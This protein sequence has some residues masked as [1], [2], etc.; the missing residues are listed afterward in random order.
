MTT[1]LQVRAGQCSESG[2][3]VR[4]EDSCGVRLAEGPLLATKGIA[5]VI[6]DGVSGS[7]GGRV[8]AETCVQGFL[9]DYY[10]TPDSWT[11]K[12]SCDKVLSALN[13]WLYGQGQQAVGGEHELVTTF[14]ALVLK[15]TTAY[16]FHVGDT[17]IYRLRE[18]EL[19]QLTRD[20]RLRRGRGR[21]YLARAMGVDA[22]VQ[23]DYRSLP[24]AAGD[25]FVLTSDG[26]HDTLGERAL[27]A[28][29]A[30]RADDPEAASR[31]L[32]EHALAAGST[33]NC[34]AQVLRVVALPL[35]D[36]S[37]LYRRL[38]ELPFPPPL[39]P[40]AILDGYRVLRELHASSRTQVFLA[41]DG[42]TGGTCALKTPSVNFEDDPGYIARFRREAWVGRRVHSPHVLRVL[43][44]ARP[45]RFL[46][47]VTE[48]LEGQTLRQWLHDHPHPPLAQVRGIVAQVAAGLRALHRL[49]MV[50]R[51]L[52]PDNVL[53][54]LSG[55]AHII[56]F[57][58]VRIRG[59]EEIATPLPEQHLLGTR[60][61]T[62]PECF[63]GH[64]GDARSD[65]FSLAVLTYEL[66]TGALPY[67]AGAL[68]RLGK[69]RPYRSVLERAPDVPPWVDA[70]LRKALSWEPE[71][72]F[73]D[74]MEFVH[75]LHHPPA[76]PGAAS[77][78][79]PLIQR[80]PLAFWRGLS[81]LLLV[82]CILLT[83]LLLR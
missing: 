8:A 23:I 6:A 34:T 43:D 59:L 19:V 32:V 45:R 54:D 66:L 3:K 55:Q 65:Q 50:H 63:A 80:N 16:L 10:S 11:V 20:H 7:G 57:G 31:A 75:A 56:D 47:T 49:E 2:R 41:L 52:K 51:D 67:G 70:V 4:N 18:G 17:R 64:P 81:L 27:G 22:G 60:G 37:E 61:Y 40:G 21:S 46:Y 71:R 36:E 82:L 1:Q 53:I 58:S 26:V 25:A 29:L 74:V 12:T 30:G 39:A 73:G 62:A 83:V 13:R 14:S 79:Q 77:A 76:H 44:S 5:A 35:E 24:V 42:E 68:P 15:S 69:P 28:L 48:H 33:D 9:A 78:P 72:R 38:A